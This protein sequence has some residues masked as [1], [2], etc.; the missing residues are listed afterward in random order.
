MADGYSDGLNEAYLSVLMPYV[1]PPTQRLET[2][3]TLATTMQ[4]EAK[5]AFE[6]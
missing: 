4:S 3:G 5:H 2:N 6:H 1:S